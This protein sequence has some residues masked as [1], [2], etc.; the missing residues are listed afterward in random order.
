MRRGRVFS[1]RSTLLR[2]LRRLCCQRKCHQ[3]GG[4]GKRGSVQLGVIR[5]DERVGKMYLLCKDCVDLP[6]CYRNAS[7][8]PQC[9][10]QAKGPCVSGGPTADDA[11]L[12]EFRT[13]VAT[14]VVATIAW[15]Q[16]CCSMYQRDG[17]PHR[18]FSNLWANVEVLPSCIHGV[19]NTKGRGVGNTEHSLD[20]QNVTNRTYE[21]PSRLSC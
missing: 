20:Q 10:R 19:G 2:R 8:P 15:E 11:V 13:V 12:E 18:D 6:M 9:S 3:L 5:G 1:R 7:C 17:A 21:R 16:P 14:T 4:R